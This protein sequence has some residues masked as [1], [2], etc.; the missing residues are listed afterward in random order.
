MFYYGSI[1]KEGIFYIKELDTY[2]CYEIEDEECH[3]FDI[4]SDKEISMR[5]ILNYLPL[6]KDSR[7]YCHFDVQE[8]SM[9]KTKKRVPVDD[10]VLFVLGVAEDTFKEF[11]L[12]LFNH[13]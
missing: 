7:V 1:F 12:P 4:L 8:E 5:G 2:L 6:E 9:I 3:L 10:D 13:A 11:K